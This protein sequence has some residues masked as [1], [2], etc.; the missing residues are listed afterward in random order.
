MLTRLIL[1][2]I[3]E[4][5]D[6]DGDET[7]ALSALDTVD[8]L[9][10]FVARQR[11]RSALTR[12]LLEAPVEQ[13]SVDGPEDDAHG[14]RLAYLALAGAT[15][16]R[17]GA[18]ATM[19]AFERCR[20]TAPAPGAGRWWASGVLGLVAVLALAC[21]GVWGYQTLRGRRA[22]NPIGPPAPAG[23][24][25]TGGSPTAGGP[26]LD[27]ALGRDL[28][29]FLI[30]LDRWRRARGQGMPTGEPGRLLEA[31]EAAQDRL[32]SRPIRAALGERAAWWLSWLLRVARELAITRR[33]DRL[34]KPYI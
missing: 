9:L 5:V 2:A 22:S 28:P 10:R 16:A 1:Q 13:A 24:F 15:Q 23:A 29:D 17:P 19:R 31:L 4:A 12:A 6:R 21:S 3:A 20:R 33:L 27:Q 25:A 14:L 8:P 26:V 18:V 11:L 34:S 7:T 30:A 32:E